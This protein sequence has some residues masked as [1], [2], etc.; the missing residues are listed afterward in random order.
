[1][2]PVS[3]LCRRFLVLLGLCT[4]AT[5]TDGYFSN[6]YGTQCK[7]LDGACTALSLDSMAAATN[8]AGMLGAGPRFDLGVNFF[9]PNRDFTVAGAPSGAPGTFG[10]APGKVSSGSLLF[11]RMCCKC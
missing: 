5:A 3:L 7:G 6:G 11:L 8:P 10:L 1:M 9:N 4:V 2:N